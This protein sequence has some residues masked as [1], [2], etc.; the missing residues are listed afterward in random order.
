MRRDSIGSR[1]DGLSGR[2]VDPRPAKTAKFFLVTRED[3]FGTGEGG[4][5][6][7]TADSFPFGNFR[8]GKVLVV[9]E[10]KTAALGFSEQIAVVIAQ[11]TDD[12]WFEL[13]GATPML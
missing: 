12:D 4:V 7:L 10:K 1:S 11:E 5:Y 6:T 9:V 8:E 3:R 2:L 13:H